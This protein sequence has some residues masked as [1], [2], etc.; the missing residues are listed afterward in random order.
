MW[1]TSSPSTVE[2]RPNSVRFVAWTCF[3]VFLNS[4]LLQ[5]WRVRYEESQII[6]HLIRQMSLL[7]GWSGCIVATALIVADWLSAIDVGYGVCYGLPWLWAMITA[8]LT[9]HRCHTQ[10]DRERR[11]WP[12]CPAVHRVRTLPIRE[13][14][15]DPPAPENHRASFH[16][17]RRAET[18]VGAPLEDT[19]RG[20]PRAGTF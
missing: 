9:V 16:Q 11:E 20:L 8:V 10:L 7:W 15:F 19:E 2:E 6:R 18:V 4:Y 17:T 13:G 14:K 1:R 3:Q 12:R 5:A